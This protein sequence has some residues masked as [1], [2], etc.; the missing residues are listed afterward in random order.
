MKI[1]DFTPLKKK[2]AKI[3]KIKRTSISS[4]NT[5]INGPI[6]SVIVAIR[7]CKPL[8]F[9]AN[10]TTRVTRSTLKSLATYGPTERAEPPPLSYGITVSRISTKLDSTIKQSNLFQVVSKYL[11]LNALIL[12]VISIKKINVKK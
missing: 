5:F 4:A 11:Q 8:F 6:E 10:R 2:T 7:A 9:L 1:P 12:N 3:E